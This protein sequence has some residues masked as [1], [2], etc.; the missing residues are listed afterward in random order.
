MN[1]RVT[2]KAGSK[3]GPMVEVGEAGELIVYV[4]QAAV[5]GKA[6]AAVVE[7]LAAYFK[8]PRSAVQIVHGVKSKRKI[9][10]ALS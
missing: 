9:I 1:Y 4:R 6:N 2:V 7:L 8:V 10:Q 5:E 3:K